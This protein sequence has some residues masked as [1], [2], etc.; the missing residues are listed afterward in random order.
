MADDSHRRDAVVEGSADAGGVAVGAALGTLGGPVGILVGA[1]GGV[2][3]TRAFR[4]VGSEMA[5][6]VLGPRQDLRVGEASAVAAELIKARLDAGGSPRADGFFD[7]DASGRATAEELLEGVL[8]T[9]ADS[10]EERKVR[11]LG[12]LYANLAFDPTV[13]RATANYL[14][15]VMR[16]LTFRQLVLMAVLDGKDAQQRAPLEQ[17]DMRFNDEMSTEVD[18]LERVGLVGRGDRGSSPKRGGATF[19]DAGSLDPRRLALTGPGVLLARLTRLSDVPPSDKA[20][21]FVGIVESPRE[22]PAE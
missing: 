17:C 4:R 10:Y 3:A 22:H 9:A 7:V 6:R 13:D 12:N 19:V 18:E 1:A 11:L 2:V 14:I 16:R 15:Q 8:L 20:D 21:V 5:K